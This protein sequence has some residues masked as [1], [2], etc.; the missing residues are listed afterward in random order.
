MKRFLK[1]DIAALAEKALNAG[2]PY[3]RTHPE[4]D[5]A[6]LD[7]EYIKTASKDIECGY[8]DRM[9]GYYDK[10]YRYNRADEGRAY[11]LGVRKAVETE[12]CADGMRIIEDAYV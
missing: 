9:V 5:R 12:G 10:W 1:K 6:E 8:R 4:C 3:Y 7:A 11:D 2:N